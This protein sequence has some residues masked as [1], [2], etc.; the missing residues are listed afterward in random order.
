M[1]QVPIHVTRMFQPPVTRL[2]SEE[3][4]EPAQANREVKSD[5]DILDHWLRLKGRTEMG[6]TARHRCRDRGKGYT[7]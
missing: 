4:Q 6:V 5:T 2:A 1:L 7:Q 3:Q